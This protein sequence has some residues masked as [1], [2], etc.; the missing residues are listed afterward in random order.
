MK[1][2]LLGIL[3]ALMILSLTSISASTTTY[4]P[5]CKKGDWVKYDVAGNATDVDAQNIE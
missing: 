4:E 1:K 2:P 3:L 5:G